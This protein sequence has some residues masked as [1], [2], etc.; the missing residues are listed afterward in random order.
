MRGS[1]LGM[2]G[3]VCAL[4]FGGA[5]YGG[6]SNEKKLQLSSNI[7]STEALLT[8]GKLNTA[9]VAKVE[10]NKDVTKIPQALTA[11]QEF[12]DDLAKKLRGAWGRAFGTGSCR[13]PWNGGKPAKLIWNQSTIPAPLAWWRKNVVFDDTEQAPRTIERPSLIIPGFQY[14]FKYNILDFV[15]S[16]GVTPK[17]LREA[18]EMPAES[19]VIMAYDMVRWEETEKKNLDNGKKLYLAYV[20]SFFVSIGKKPQLSD[21]ANFL[22]NRFCKPVAE[23]LERQCVILN[24]KTDSMDEKSPEFDTFLSEFKQVLGLYAAYRSFGVEFSHDF[25]YFDQNVPSPSERYESTEG[26]RRLTM[27]CLGDPKY[28]GTFN[29]NE[30][31]QY[32]YKELKSAIE[33][34]TEH[35][36]RKF[37]TRKGYDSK[38]SY[39]SEAL[40]EESGSTKFDEVLEECENRYRVTFLPVK[41][42]DFGKQAIELESWRRSLVLTY[43]FFPIYG[44]DG[45][46]TVT[47]FEDAGYNK[48]A[49]K[50]YHLFTIGFVCTTRDRV[51]DFGSGTQK[52]VYLG[53]SEKYMNIMDPYKT[54]GAYNMESDALAGRRF[55]VLEGETKDPETGKLLWT[56]FYKMVS[57][58]ELN[59]LYEKSRME[60]FGM[61]GRYKS[62]YDEECGCNV[63]FLSPTEFQK[64]LPSSERELYGK[65]LESGFSRNFADL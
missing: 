31:V 6:N 59:K 26:D 48:V 56:S 3:G 16:T 32:N 46:K 10:C 11:Y 2:I 8:W 35:L 17:E 55:V 50:T 41:Y 7:A 47:R 23:L 19:R 52:A 61:N 58:E 43:R 15:P 5:L 62:W 63:R 44:Q 60:V 25:N 33:K 53:E 20:R 21:C 49:L 42:Y 30:G 4:T 18:R 14:S 29:L 34:L 27:S 40:E 45:A 37:G 12:Y 38:K 65:S 36:N 54:K 1:Y 64:L 24:Q 51:E 39:F 13:R 22:D 9:H 28:E 57:V